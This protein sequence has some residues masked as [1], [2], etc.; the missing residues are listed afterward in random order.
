MDLHG[1][2]TTKALIRL[3]CN[4]FMHVKDRLFH[5]EAHFVCYYNIFYPYLVHF[6]KMYFICGNKIDNINSYVS[7]CANNFIF[8]MNSYS[9]PIIISEIHLTVLVQ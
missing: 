1:Q 4:K 6:A 5:N 7:F 2:S 3:I 9:S 8:V